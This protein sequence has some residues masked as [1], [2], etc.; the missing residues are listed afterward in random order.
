MEW[1]KPIPIQPI[2][3]PH[4]LTESELV[5]SLREE[6]RTL[7]EVLN[8][9]L[10]KLQQC[11]DDKYMLVALETPNPRLAIKMMKK[12]NSVYM[13]SCKTLESKKELLNEAIIYGDPDIITTVAYYLYFSL[14]TIDFGDIVI[15][16]K[17][18]CRLFLSFLLEK[19]YNEFEMVTLRYN[20]SDEYIK[21]RL[22]RA[23]AI[24]NIFERKL[25][26]NKCREYCDK[27][28]ELTELRKSIVE[29]ISYVKHSKW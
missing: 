4:I 22:Q 10:V 29:M 23:L 24:P 19:D 14:N 18:S 3:Q 5:L 16:N 15:N 28:S 7:Q 12:Y 1:F 20:K 21:A 13:Y 11:A 25:E 27:H 8:V 2:K 6:I 26:L 17:I 9:T